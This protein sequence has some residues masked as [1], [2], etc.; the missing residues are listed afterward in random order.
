MQI[1]S[2]TCGGIQHISFMFPL[3]R[4]GARTPLTDKFWPETQVGTESTGRGCTA[5]VELLRNN[6]DDQM[7]DAGKV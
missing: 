7:L 2:A 1:W 6:A 5:H 4:H 3:S